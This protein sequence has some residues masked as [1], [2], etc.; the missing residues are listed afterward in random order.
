MSLWV[1]EY[2]L[3]AAAAKIG[4]TIDELIHLAAENRLPIY[5]R[6]NI[7]DQWF[8][9]GGLLG[10][11]TDSHRQK[12]NE[13][14]YKFEDVPGIAKR[15]PTPP[16]SPHTQYAG[17]K[18]RA[19]VEI[20]QEGERGQLKGSVRGLWQ[21][22]HHHFAWLAEHDDGC[23]GS[24]ILVAHSEDGKGEIRIND[25][26]LPQAHDMSGLIVMG[27]DLRLLLGGEP[28]PC[29]PKLKQVDE[30]SHIRSDRRHVANQKRS[31]E[32]REWL[33]AIAERARMVYPELCC[34]AAGWA[35]AI[36]DHKRELCYQPDDDDFQL[37]GEQRLARVISAAIKENKLILETRILSPNCRMTVT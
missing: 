7:H 34:S 18:H 32:L 14:N 30:L 17:M 28:T 6:L 35:R 8:S 31:N 3:S 24:S 26:P 33:I 1:K 12:I 25:I 37:P 19:R 10:V 21:V 22:S 13:N 11:V 9:I 5:V 16:T 2:K 27:D 29:E 20:W 36:L 15:M 23:F 4:A